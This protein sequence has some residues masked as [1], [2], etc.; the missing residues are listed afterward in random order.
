[1]SHDL[2]TPLHA[3]LSYSRFGIN[4]IEKVDQA[5]ILTYFKRI[6]TA[7]KTLQSMLTNLVD[8]SRMESGRMR[9]QKYKSNI[10]LIVDSVIDTFQGEIDAK[11]LTVRVESTREQH[12]VV[13]DQNRIEQVL[14]NL[15]S[16]AIKFSEDGKQ[17]LIAV[18]E[19][20]LNID[21]NTLPGIRL[22]VIDEGTGI[23]GINTKT[24]LEQLIRNPTAGIGGKGL[25]LP[26]CNEIIKS[27]E[28]T[29]WCE[30]TPSGGAAFSF[31]L[32]AKP[33][34]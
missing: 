32:P 23:P 1:M 13:C 16:N 10:L 7:G 27:H 17:I 11:R 28:G 12:S 18:K 20:E 6:E 4:K 31:T 30:N 34:D 33:T 15:L 21:G 26:I 29:I 14:E 24:T 9:Y 5:K 22:D 3:I 25:G 8:L 2:R 19:S